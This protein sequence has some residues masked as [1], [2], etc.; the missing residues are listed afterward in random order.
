MPNN[1]LYN[2]AFNTIARSVRGKADYYM[3]CSLEAG[4]SRFG[5]MI[6]DGNNFSVVKNGIDSSLYKRN[7]TLIANA[8]SALHTGG[9]PVFL[10]IGR[11]T[12]QKNHPFLIEVFQ[13]IKEQLPNALLLLVGTGEDIDKI[14]QQV[15]S[16]NLKDS[17]RFLGTRTDIPF[18]L[19]ASDVFLFPSISEGLGIAF[20]EAQAAGLECIVSEGVPKFAC[21]TPRVS[22]LNIGSA[23]NWADV[24][25]AAYA[26]SLTAPNDQTSLIEECGFDIRNTASWLSEFYSLHANI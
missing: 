17:V 10:H 3:A 13:K 14:R 1:S 12:A 7:S 6:T 16:S 25:V 5:K 21:I 2:I 8:K 4:I 20:I 18:I 22:H 9:N 11:F 26:R 23:Q 19:Q 24:A 15:I